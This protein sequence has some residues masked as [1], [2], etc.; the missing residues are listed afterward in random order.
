MGRN[1]ERNVREDACGGWRPPWPVFFVQAE[2]CSLIRG[3]KI[4]WI[5]IVIQTLKKMEPFVSKWSENWKMHL[6]IT[7]DLFYVKNCIGLKNRS[8][9][10]EGDRERC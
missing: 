5:E 10:L 1:E 6:R 8:V 9:I 7:Q 2:A 4:K 3:Q